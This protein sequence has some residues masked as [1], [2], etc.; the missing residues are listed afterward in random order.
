METVPV[1]RSKSSTNW[2]SNRFFLLN[3]SLCHGEFSWVDMWYGHPMSW[4]KSLR[5]GLCHPPMGISQYIPS[6]MPIVGIIV[7][8]N[9]NHSLIRIL[10]MVVNDI[11]TY[12]VNIGY[13][14]VIIVVE[15]LSRS[16]HV[17][18]W[19]INPI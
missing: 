7:V 5:I 15:V 14:H 11:N 17:K 6:N 16:N 8:V 4:I 9:D 19:L 10:I 18:K 3:L 12:H 13:Y 1:F 2:P